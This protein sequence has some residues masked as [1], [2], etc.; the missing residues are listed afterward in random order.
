MKNNKEKELKNAIKSGCIF[1]TL[2]E[3]DENLDELY[4]EIYLE[5]DLL[6]TTDINGFELPV[7]EDMINKIRLVDSEGEK[8]SIY[9]VQFQHINILYLKNLISEELNHVIIHLEQIAKKFLPE[10]C[11]SHIKIKGT[12]DSLI[13][14]LNLKK[15]HIKF[16]SIGYGGFCTS[17][18]SYIEYYP[19]EDKIAVWGRNNS[20]GT[21]VFKRIFG[22]SDFCKN[23]N[24][25]LNKKAKQWLKSN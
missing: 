20:K 18:E 17:E 12:D 6:Y 9:H 2:V 24:I 10:G 1:E 19:N 11:Y 3:A 14:S 23:N 22:I 5:N 21:R 13:N 25:I 8:A 16:I 7:T 4:K 15:D